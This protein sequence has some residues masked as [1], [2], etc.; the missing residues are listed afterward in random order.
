MMSM[1]GKMMVTPVELHRSLNTRV[2]QAHTQA[3]DTIFRSGKAAAGAQQSWL[4]RCCGGLGDCPGLSTPPVAGAAPHDSFGLC[5]R[6]SL[7]I[8]L[9]QIHSKR[10]AGGSFL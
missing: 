7:G 8:A 2:W 3:W 5:K 6:L 4:R 1:F 10:K 9:V